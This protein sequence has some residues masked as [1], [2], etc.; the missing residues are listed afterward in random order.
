MVELEDI[1]S[2]E[3]TLM[4]LEETTD[5]EDEMVVLESE[6][7]L[8]VGITFSV[9]EA[10]SRGVSLIP[11]AELDEGTSSEVTAGSDILVEVRTDD[12]DEMVVLK[13][14]AVLG[15]RITFSVCEAVN[16]GVSLISEAELDEDNSSEVTAGS[17]KLVEVP[18]DDEDEMVVL[19]SEA[20]LDVGIMFS[21]C[22]AVSREAELEE[23]TSSDVIAGSD[24]LLEVP[25]DEDEMVVLE[26]EEVLGVGITFSVCEAASR[27]VSLIPAAELDEGTSSEVTAGSDILV[28]VR[29]D[30]EDEVV[31]L[32]SEAV[33]DVGIMF[34]VCEAVSR[35]AEL[36][37]DTSSDVTA[38]SDKLLEV[39]MVEK[40]DK[41]ELVSVVAK[42]EDGIGVKL[43]AASTSLVIDVT[44]TVS[45]EVGEVIRVVGAC[46]LSSPAGSDV[47]GMSG[48]SKVDAVAGVASV[49]V[50]VTACVVAAAENWV[51]VV[52]I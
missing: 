47:V 41:T 48:T 37:E 9:C 1:T 34:S 20:V 18:T 13:S 26:S 49:S 19:D 16:R 29:T 51:E 4:L 5:D 2:S 27:G 35:E 15:V 6:E 45:G 10:A 7:V 22:E 14:E 46:V 39:T 33:L 31:V 17:N 28:E 38:G 43:L 21:V 23:D 3:V 42:V 44:T 30:D 36:E 11:A 12:E 24:K 25:T 50:E 8:G 40:N 32:D 52:P